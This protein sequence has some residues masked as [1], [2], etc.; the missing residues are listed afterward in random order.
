MQVTNT[1]STILYIEDN[2]SNIE[3]IEEVFA[4]HRPEILLVTSKFGK[5]TIELAKKHKPGLIL[6]DLDLPDL[7][8]IEV[9][10]QLLADE[11]TK[12][13]P[14]IIISADAMSFQIDKL[15]KAGATGYLTKPLDVVL[16]LRTIEQHT[17][18]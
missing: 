8:G 4:E 1:A 2:R 12:S 18:I 9:L 3:L 6:L 10:A 11:H 7:N 17:A 15:M 16:F 14:V 5:K 13:I